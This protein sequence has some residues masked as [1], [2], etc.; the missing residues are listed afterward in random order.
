MKLIVPETKHVWIKKLSLE[1]HY[2]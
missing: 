1:M 2:R